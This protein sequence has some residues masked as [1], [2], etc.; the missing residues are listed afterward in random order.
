M[1]VDQFPSQARL[2]RR[3]REV[4]ARAP[5]ERNDAE[6]HRAYRCPA[7][8]PPS[9]PPTEPVGQP[10]PQR[11]PA[12]QRSLDAFHQLSRRLHAQIRL[13]ELQTDLT[14]LIVCPLT[15]LAAGKMALELERLGQAQLLV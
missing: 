5:R 4:Q 11:P 2:A 12:R 6:S 9:C 15:L 1:I 10:L 7:Q 14:L 8:R 13:P 3:H